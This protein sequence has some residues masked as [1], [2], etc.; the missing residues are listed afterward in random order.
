MFL[1][2]TPEPLFR[3]LLLQVIC[4]IIL[5]REE[6]DQIRAKNE[7]KF[8]WSQKLIWFGAR[9]PN[10]HILDLISSSLYREVKEKAT[11]SEDE[12]SFRSTNRKKYLLRFTIASHAKETFE[13]NFLIGYIEY[14]IT[15]QVCHMCI[16]WS[17]DL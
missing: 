13:E 4:Q 8:L 15:L 1:D 7:Q 3:F 11:D 14:G 5:A 6:T 10:K 16:A 17:F 12:I 9:K 2:G